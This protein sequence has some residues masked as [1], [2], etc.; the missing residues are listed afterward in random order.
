MSFADSFVLL[1]VVFLAFCILAVGG[2]AY[3]SICGFLVN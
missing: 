1:L 3:V 2:V